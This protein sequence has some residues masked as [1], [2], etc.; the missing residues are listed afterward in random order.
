MQLTKKAIALIDLSRFYAYNEVLTLTARDGEDMK[1]FSLNDNDFFLIMPYVTLLDS[2]GKPLESGANRHNEMRIE[3]SN[4][5]G[6]NFF[7]SPITVQAFNR[8]YKN[9]RYAGAYLTD[10]ARYR[11]KLNGTGHPT[12][13]INKFPVRSE[14]HLIGYSLGS[15]EPKYSINNVM[16]RVRSDRPWTLDKKFTLTS[17][18]DKQEE[19]ITIGLEEFWVNEANVTLTDSEGRDITLSD[20]ITDAFTVKMKGSDEWVM[21]DNMSLRAF[22]QLWQSKQ[23]KG[24][25]LK[26]RTDYWFTIKANSFPADVNTLKFDAKTANFTTGDTLTGGTSGASGIIAGIIED[27]AVGTFILTD[28]SGTFQDNETVTGAVSGSATSDGTVTAGACLYNIHAQLS[29]QGYKLESNKV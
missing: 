9:E 25:V 10:S 29:L 4:E 14:F 28:I 15:N 11:V 6:W 5:N 7:E 26:E 22:N 16:N 2:K 17:N 1:S 20:S 8:L 23:W 19:K 12:K 18:S 13:D 27:G 24:I 21:F 3:F